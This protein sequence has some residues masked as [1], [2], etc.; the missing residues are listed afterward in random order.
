MSGGALP[1]SD[2]VDALHAQA[3]SVLNVKVLVPIVLDLGAANYQKWHGLFLVT[4]G[5]YALTDHVLS[6]DAFPHH[7]S[8]AR[9]D[10]VVLTWLYG[11]IATDLL[12][13]IIQPDGNARL[14]CLSLEQMFL[15][16]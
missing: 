16:H 8:W 1:T 6:D 7:A 9:M 14:V 3:V 4:L 5:K 12:E 13:T 11:T 2:T 10:C 15:G